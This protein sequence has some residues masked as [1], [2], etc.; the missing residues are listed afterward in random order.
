MSMKFV[1]ALLALAVM[2]I[3]GPLLAHTKVGASVPADGAEVKAPT[4]I[5]L[6]FPAAVK[7]TA[8]ILENEAG[9]VLTLGALPGEMAEAFNIAI[10]DTLVAGR[11]RVTWRSV[12]ADSHMVSGDFRFSV[13]D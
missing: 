4:E 10:E 13:I 11:Y 6:T 1:T 8:V 5:R 9:D 12:S 2:A 7:L 3:S